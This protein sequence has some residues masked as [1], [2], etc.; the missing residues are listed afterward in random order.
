ME[1]P[2]VPQRA[3]LC[4]GGASNTKYKHRQQ[5]DCRYATIQQWLF[6]PWGTERRNKRG[7]GLPIH[8]PNIFMDTWGV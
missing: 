5:H 7:F 1:N 4:R 6:F 2:D 3:R 8:T